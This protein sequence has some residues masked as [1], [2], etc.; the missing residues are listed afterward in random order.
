VCVSVCLVSDSE[1]T[2]HITEYT[3]NDVYNENEDTAAGSDG[4]DSE[5]DETRP[6]VKVRKRSYDRLSCCFYCKKI[7]KRKM[8]RHLTNV[9]ANEAEIA[10]VL[11]CK[12]KKRRILG[13]TQLTNLGNFNYNCKVIEAGEGDLIIGRVTKKN[14]SLQQIIDAYL[15]CAYCF[16]FYMKSDLWRHVNKCRFK[17]SEDDTSTRMLQGAVRNKTLSVDPVFKEELL[18]SM[19]SDEVT[20]TVLNNELIMKY[21]TSLY[22]RL[23]RSKAHDISRRL[24]QLARLISSKKGRPMCSL[25]SP[26]GD[27]NIS[28][29]GAENIPSEAAENT[30]EIIPSEENVD[31]S[32]SPTIGLNSCG[33]EESCDL[34]MTGVYMDCVVADVM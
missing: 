26:L 23:G 30:T 9:H 1:A 28:S 18:D 31:V 17:P 32:D 24:Q 6:A 29:G 13:I 4:N 21:G 20:Q 16:V 25:C 22:R 14:M 34:Y 27:E 7:L 12:D 15:P 2:T 10:E 8:L 11:A 33:S 5:E 19:R 3:D